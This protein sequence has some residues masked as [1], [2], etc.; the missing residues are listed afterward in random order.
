MSK[1]GYFLGGMATG[2]VGVAALD[3]LD[4]KYGIL[5]A[6]GKSGDYNTEDEALEEQSAET[7]PPSWWF[8]PHPPFNPLKHRIAPRDQ[9]ALLNRAN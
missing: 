9:E 4:E 5:P 1:L 2:V 6:Y 8:L 3:F 7:R